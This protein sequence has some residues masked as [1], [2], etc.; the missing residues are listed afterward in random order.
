M[1]A[2]PSK[3]RQRVETTKPRS[4]KPSVAPV[5][6]DVVEEEEEIE[7]EEEEPEPEAIEDDFADLKGI[8][9]RVHKLLDLSTY[10]PEYR[11]WLDTGSPE[12][13]EALGSRVKGLPYG[14]LYEIAGHKHGGKTTLVTVLAG[15]AQRDGAVVGYIDLENSY[16]PTWATKLGM[17]PE[18]VYLINPKLIKASSKK[19]A[20]IVL[21]SAEQMFA[22]AEAVMKALHK[23]GRK[24]QFWI[25][26]SVANI[27]TQMAIADGTVDR[28]MRTNMDRASLLSAMLPRWCGYAANYNAMVMMINQLR[29]KPVAFGDPFY[30]PGGD[31]VG[32]TASIQARVARIKGGKMLQAGKTVGIVGKI[33]NIKNKAGE[34]SVQDNSAGFKIR[35]DRSPAKIE[36]MAVS[37]AEAFIKGES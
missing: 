17:R 37:Q 7:E 26:D 35:W 32:F 3:A 19:D 2:V 13:N 10:E 5:V 33:Q 34:G 1:A 28:N 30:S 11:Y 14:K 4:I 15:M 27:Q 22:E 16:D 12:L 6:D 31:A 21:E 18:G 23:R 36:F 29:R 9:E 20:D 8:Q 25:L 24:K